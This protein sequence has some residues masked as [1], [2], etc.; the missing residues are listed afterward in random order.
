MCSGPT[1]VAASAATISTASAAAH[2]TPPTRV[3]TTDQYGSP[4]IMDIQAVAK[5][6]NRQLQDQL[7]ED[8]A[9][10][11]EISISSPVRVDAQPLPRP[12]LRMIS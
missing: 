3:Q 12:L 5:K 4:G 1:G 6:V 7:G 10:N 11:I 8:A 2:F 9:G